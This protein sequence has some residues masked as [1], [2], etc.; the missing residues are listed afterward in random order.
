MASIEATD[1]AIRKLLLL[2]LLRIELKDGCY[3]LMIAGN[4]LILQL[5]ITLLLAFRCAYPMA[6]P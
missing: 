6:S 2:W 4:T 3:R 1:K 5:R